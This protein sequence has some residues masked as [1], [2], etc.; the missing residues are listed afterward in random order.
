MYDGIGAILKSSKAFS[1]KRKRNYEISLLIIEH[2]YS[3]R[4]SLWQ[5]FKQLERI[6]MK[7]SI[8]L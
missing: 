5:M 3:T 4:I 1:R 6:K 8:V 7:N 2:F